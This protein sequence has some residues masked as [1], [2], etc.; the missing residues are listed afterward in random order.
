MK[1][2]STLSIFSSILILDCTCLAL[3]ALALNNKRFN[4]KVKYFIVGDGELREELESYCNEIGIA[5]SSPE[6]NNEKANLVF[7]SWI[8]DM[9]R[10]VAGVDIVALTSNNEGTPVSLIEAQAGNKPVV[11]TNVG[12]IENVILNGETGYLSPRE[13]AHAFADNLLTL[14]KNIIHHLVLWL[15][16]G[17]VFLVWQ[18]CQ[19]NNS[20]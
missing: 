8:E 3:D 20:I 5:Y 12:G 1:T 2:S 14:Q 13:D 9:D 10:V 15:V 16:I 18:I 6:K 7:T 4:G 17:V 11:S 19:T